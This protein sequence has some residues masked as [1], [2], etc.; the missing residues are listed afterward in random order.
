[1][2]IKYY[3][4]ILFTIAT[5][6]FSV[7]DSTKS[8]IEPQNSPGTTSLASTTSLSFPSSSKDTPEY[9]ASSIKYIGP[10]NMANHFSQFEAHKS[11]QQSFLES[12]K[13]VYG[14]VPIMR[15]LNQAKLSEH[16][17]FEVLMKREIAWNYG[18]LNEFGLMDCGIDLKFNAGVVAGYIELIPDGRRIAI[19]KFKNIKEYRIAAQEA[20]EVQTKCLIKGLEKSGSST[21]QL[22]QDTCKRKIPFCFSDSWGQIWWKVNSE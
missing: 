16:E 12:L 4:S 11:T 7:F 1:M 17:L 15:D 22:T 2:A 13:A 14:I 9:L 18:D 19:Q 21:E 6:C 8:F 20:K 10:H 5:C 3:S